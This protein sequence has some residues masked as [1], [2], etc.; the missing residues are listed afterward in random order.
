[1]SNYRRAQANGGTFFFTVITHQ[2]RQI[3]T[4]PEARSALRH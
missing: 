4:D 3:L 2:Q 1:M